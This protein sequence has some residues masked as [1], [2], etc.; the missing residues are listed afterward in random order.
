MVLTDHS[1][2]TSL[3]NE[4]SH[5]FCGSHAVFCT[6]EWVRAAPSCAKSPKYGPGTIQLRRG[7]RARCSARRP[8]APGGGRGNGRRCSC[9]G[10]RKCRGSTQRNVRQRSRVVFRLS[11]SWGPE[12]TRDRPTLLHAGAGW[13]ATW[14]AF[15]YRVARQKACEPILLPRQA[16]ESGKQSGTGSLGTARCIR[17]GP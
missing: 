17:A 4:S 8:L 5:N 16:S 10:Q 11:H 7:S 6:P 1:F 9:G 15:F 13:R 2:R 3:T 12:C 14:H